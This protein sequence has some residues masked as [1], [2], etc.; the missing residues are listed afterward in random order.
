MGAAVLTDP[1]YGSQGIRERLTLALPGLPRYISER[2]II[3]RM[4]E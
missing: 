4:G 3:L 2:T 1:G